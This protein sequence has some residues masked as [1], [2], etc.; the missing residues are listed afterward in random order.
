[1]IEAAYFAVAAGLAAILGFAAHRAS[2]CTVKA[3]AEVMTT[4]GVVMLTSM[5][6]VVAW[7]VCVTAVLSLVLPGEAHVEPARWQLSAYSV[8]GGALFG[9]GAVL[10]R[11]CAFSMLTR[12]VDGNM[13]MLLGLAGTAAGTAGYMLAVRDA[14]IAPALPD[15]SPRV[16]AAVVPALSIAAVC[17]AA[18]ELVRLLRTAAHNGPVK[19]R[20]AASRYRQSTGAALIGVCGAALYWHFGSFTFTSSVAGTLGGMADG[21]G[22]RSVVPWA[23]FLSVVAGMALSSRQRGSFAWRW[24]SKAE[25]GLHFV[26]GLL[27]GLGAALAPGGNDNLIM[28]GIPQLSPHAIPAYLALL[29]SIAAVLATMKLLS[30][31]IPSVVCVGDVCTDR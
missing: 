5:A 12:L 11:G 15:V 10:N 6:K 30:G 22:I 21:S 25:S 3:V 4:G 8:L 16:F 31:A 27:M 23:L 18:W 26:G 19:Q 7:V 1:M 29:A 2:I 20:V 13:G 28:N 9:I 17:W 14:G 24:P